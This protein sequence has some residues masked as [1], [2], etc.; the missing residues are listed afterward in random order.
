MA[1]VQ[2][3]ATSRAV[4]KPRARPRP[5]SWHDFS[6][7]L[8]YEALCLGKGEFA[9]PS[10]GKID[11]AKGRMKEAAGDLTGDRSMKREGKRDRAAGTVKEKIEKSVDRAKDF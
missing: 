8:M 3:L 7:A 6:T 10:G 5:H 4:P 11:K 2:A 9:M 1:A